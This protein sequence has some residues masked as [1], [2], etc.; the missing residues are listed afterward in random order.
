MS[1]KKEFVKLSWWILEQKLLYYGYQNLKLP[2][3][4]SD[5]EYDLKEE[6]YKELAVILGEN[7][8]ASDMVG[9]DPD[10]PS[11][12]LVLEKYLKNQ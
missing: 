3:P 8:T 1:L 9:F 10:K 7:P 12:K 4:V 5:N 2:K 11:S 6:R